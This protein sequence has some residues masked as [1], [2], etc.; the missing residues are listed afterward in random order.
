[1]TG[2]RAS[3]RISVPPTMKKTFLLLALVPAL[4]SGADASAPD[5]FGAIHANDIDMLKAFVASDPA[6]A[7]SVLPKNG[8]TP[9]HFAAKLDRVEAARHL[10][11]AGVDPNAEAK[12]KTTPLHWAA[13]AGSADVL[14]LL[15]ANKAVVDARAGNGLAPLHLAARGGSVECIVRL[16]EAGADPNV[17]DNEGNTPLHEAA[18][19]NRSAAV[20]ALVARGADPSLANAKGKIPAQ[21]S[22]D[23]AV[24]G[25]LGVQ[26]PAPAAPPPQT[27]PSAAAAKA[28]ADPGKTPAERYNDFANDPETK[29]NADGTLYNGGW[30]RGRFEGTGVLV[31][32]PDGER[33]EGSFR[34]GRREGHGTYY[35]ANGDSLE[36]EWDDDIPDG[37]GVFV[38]ATG[39]TV[40]GTWRNGVLRRGEGTFSTISGSQSYGHW[41]NGRLISSQPVSR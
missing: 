15:L 19:K 1:M 27:A 17:A 16:V 21:L 14:R 18:A 4:V 29:R 34:R 23:P 38:F 26:A 6:T 33:Y 24:L 41:E 30:N 32:N 39:G 20:A 28:F 36:C 31:V 10:L 37:D 40:R 5:I 2:P 7:S 11:R 35:Y 8:V 3:N 25:A 22:S 13:D 12:N 9:L